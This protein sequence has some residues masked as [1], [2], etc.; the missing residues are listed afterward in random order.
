M[1]AAL[2]CHIMACATQS[3]ALVFFV[4]G[5]KIIEQNADP[6]KLLLFYLRKGLRLS[7]TKY[8]CGIGGCGAC[9]VMIST[10]EPTSKKIMHYPANSCLLPICSLHGSAVTTVEGVGSKKTRVHPIQERL[11]K[12]HG[13]QCGFCT[14]GMVMSMYALL[15]NHP[16]PSMEQI[17]AALDGNLCRCTGYRPIIDTYKSFAGETACCQL[18]GTGQCCLDKEDVCSSSDKGN[19]MHSDLCNPEEFQPVD[20]TQEFIFPPELMR[21]AQEQQKRTLVFHGERT[22]WISPTNL[23]ELLELKAMYPKAPLVVGNTSVGLEM[24][25]DGVHHPVIIHPTRIPALHVD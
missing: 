23:R 2:L 14:P 6:E 11:A 1:Q 5:R 15:R 8:S 18:R 24:K 17:T 12:C 13:S 9:T 4:N 25:L 20:P 21:M 22:T 3:D 7:G 10:Y 19:Q 16:D